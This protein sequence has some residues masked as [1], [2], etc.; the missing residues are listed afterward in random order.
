[1]SLLRSEGITRD[2]VSI[3]RSLRWSERDTAVLL[4]L[5]MAR[6]GEKLCNTRRIVRENLESLGATGVPGIE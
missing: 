5:S 4:L 6:V 1:M 3:D 2:F